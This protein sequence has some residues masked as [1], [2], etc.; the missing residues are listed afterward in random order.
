MDE[1]TASA[2][3]GDRVATN[4]IHRDKAYQ[5]HEPLELGSV[6]LKWYDLAAPATPVAAGTRAQARAFLA[7]EHAAGRGGLADEL[8]FAI[9]HRCGERFHFLL[10]VTWRNENEMWESVYALDRAP[11][12]ERFESAGAHRGTFCVWELACVMA[13]KQAWERY[14]RSARDDAAQRMWLAEI[15][16]GTA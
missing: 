7:R 16:A 14:L 1:A 4:Y 15:S 11:D 13:E 6:T 2:L 3:H 9:L 5:P 12:F 8:G 10:V